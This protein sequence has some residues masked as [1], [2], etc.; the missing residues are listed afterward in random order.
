MNWVLP[1]FGQGLS[2][3][4]LSISHPQFTHIQMGLT[5]IS[6]WFFKLNFKIGDFSL[7]FCVIFWWDAWRIWI[8]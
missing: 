3:V 1:Q 8:I 5:S 6:S 2:L 7:K 4:A